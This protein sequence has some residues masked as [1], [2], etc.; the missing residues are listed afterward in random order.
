M[1]LI[2]KLRDDQ[3][4]MKKVVEDMSR[5]YEWKSNQD[6][7]H[8]QNPLTTLKTSTTKSK[9]ATRSKGKEIAKAPSPLES[10]HEVVSDKEETPRDKE[11]QK[12][13]IRTRAMQQN[14][15]HWFNYKEFRHV[16]KECELGAHYVY[17]ANIHDVIPAV[18]EDTGPIFD[19]EPLEKVHPHDDYNVFANERQYPKQ[20][21][22]INDTYVV[23]KD[24]NNITPDSLYM[25][26]NEEKVE[27]DTTQE[28]EHVLLA[29]LIENV[30]LEIYESKKINK[31]L[32]KA[33]TSLT[34]ELLRYTK[35]NY[36]KEDEIEI[37]KAY[38]LLKEQKAR[39]DKSCSEAAFQVF[40][41]KQKFLELEKQL[42]E[43]KNTT[44]T[45]KYEKD[46][47][48]KF[49]KTCEDKEIAKVICMEKQVK[50]LND[51]VFKIGQ[52][53]QTM[54][55]LNKNCQTSFKKP[56]YLKKVQNAKPCLYDIG[57]YNDN[58]ANMLTLDS[59]ETICL[60]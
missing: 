33:N 54:N 39:S 16:A 30:K 60:A 37:A 50:S 28:D 38:G 25:C 8:C 59:D 34:R 3:K 49:Y 19:K 18:D 9:A 12:E 6:R 43:H 21:E 29:S 48:K 14:G 5:S 27:H 55:M 24:D 40:N 11:I 22:S 45:L 2:Q 23:E 1:Q 41:I 52:S 44:S 13:T 31:D 20:P 51:I 46:E 15:I 57:C 35:S 17:M 26:N 53:I 32:K 42:L 58:I 4:C 56:R 36:V 47:Q 7:E 10:D